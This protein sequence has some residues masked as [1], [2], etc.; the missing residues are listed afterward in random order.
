MGDPLGNVAM[1]NVGGIRVFG[2]TYPARIWS[3]YMTD[4]LAPLPNV[5]FTAPDRVPGGKFIKDK[6]SV[7][8]KTPTTTT[9]AKPGAP[10]SSTA[11]GGTTTPS[12]T[13]PTPTS[14]ATSSPPTTSGKP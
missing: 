8:K 1:R 7:V 10:T 2:G 11:P 12:S 9:T 6:Y 3:A 4:A 14:S 13:P 5:S